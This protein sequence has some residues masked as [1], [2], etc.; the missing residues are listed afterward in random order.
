MTR[1]MTAPK[2]ETKRY[3]MDEAAAELRMSRRWLQSFIQQNP[4]YRI[5]GN[6]KLFDQEH[7]DQLWKAL[8]CPSDSKRPAKAARRSIV[9]VGHSSE[10]ELIELRN[11]LKNER[12]R[13]SSN[14]GETKSSPEPTVIPLRR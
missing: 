11:L 12:R 2:P 9:S 10:S 5:A 8:P 14:A 3:T 1:P 6:K 4:F 7:I 13:P